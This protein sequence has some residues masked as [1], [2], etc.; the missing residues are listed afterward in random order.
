MIEVI[1]F[2]HENPNPSDDELHGWAE[3]TG[4][5]VEEV[6]E[7]VYTLATAM[8]ELLHNGK[9]FESGLTEDDLDPDEI[10]I[11]IEIESEHTTNDMIA[12]RIAMDHLVEIPDY[13]SR[14]VDMED[15][16]KK[17]MGE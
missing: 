4:L 15:E 7:V 16:A 14:L 11:G 13:Y 10:D 3:E 12:K 9:A 8:V 5:E 1:K 6:E 17:D 2:L